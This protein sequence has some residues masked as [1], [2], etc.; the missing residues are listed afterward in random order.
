MKWTTL[1]GNG[2][3]NRSLSDVSFILNENGPKLGW[4]I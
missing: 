1:A 4:D 2:S 3:I